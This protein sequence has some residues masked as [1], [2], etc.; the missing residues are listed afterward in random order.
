MPSIEEFNALPAAEAGRLLLECLASGRW[1]AGVASGRPYPG[2]RELWRAGRSALEHLTDDEWLAAIEAHPRI[3]ERGGHARRASAREQSVAMRASGETLAALA[4]EN[5]RYER[6]FG[7]VFLIRADGRTAD[8]ILSELRRRMS[9]EP[10][11][12]LAEA[13]RELTR[14]TELR[15]ER[16]VPE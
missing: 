4:E 2:A 15:L 8:E 7:H 9:N 14:I 5:R 13:R 12:E 1:S 3:G 11:A 10:A 16:L 6:R